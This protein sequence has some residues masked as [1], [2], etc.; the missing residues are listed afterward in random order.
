[1][2]VAEDHVSM[3]EDLCSMPETTGLYEIVVQAADGL[4]FIQAVIK[5]FPELLILGFSMPKLNGILA[6]RDLQNIHPEIKIIVLT[7]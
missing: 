7:L 6:I 4:G 2:V 1:M 5:T 3:L